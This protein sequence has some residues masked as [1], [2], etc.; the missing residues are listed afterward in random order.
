MTP[1]AVECE[2]ALK[3]PA[4]QNGL[5]FDVPVLSKSS[6]SSSSQPSA[7]SEPLEA[8]LLAWTLLLYRNSNG[9]PVQF[10]WSLSEVGASEVATFE[11]NTSTLPWAGADSVRAARD[12]IRE[13]LRQ[14][15]PADQ[16]FAVDRYTF[17]F[18]DEIAP[19][20]SASVVEDGDH[21]VSWGNIQLQAVVADGSLCIRPHWRE[22]LGASF[23]AN[24]FAQSLIEILTTTLG[25]DLAAPI[26]SVLALGD[27]DK[28]VIWG[29]NKDVPP[30]THAC[31]HTLI[32]DMVRE[33]P[34]APAICSWDG[35]FTYQEVEDHS[36][37]LAHH[38][39]S[40]GLKVGDVVPLCFEKSRWT[41]IALMAVNKAG[42][43]FV[44]MDPSQPLQRRQTMAAVV[45]AP[46]ILTSRS[47]GPSGMETAPE[48]QTV[49]VDEPTL[50]SLAKSTSPKG[51]LPDVPTDSLLYCIF[52]SGSTGVPKGVM[53]DHKTY[54]TSAIIRS[55][56]IGYA[57]DSR[58]LDF[59]SY[60]FD[61]SI[62]S[63][64]CTLLRGG[65]LCIP[66]DDDRMNDLSGA[67]RRLKVNMANMTP[68]VARI[69][70]ADI[71]PS[72]H[73]LGLGGESSSAADIANWGKET[74]IVVGYGP[75]ECTIGCTVNPSAAG[76]P[77]VSIGAG[78][79]AVIWLVDP[80]DHNKLVPVGA[81]G[82]LLVEGP[83][84]GQG[85]LGDPEKTAAA[86]IED[87]TWLLEG[88]G[89][90]PGRHGRLYKTGDLV[91]YD[92]D[93]KVGFIF[94]GRKDTQIKLRGQR[95]ELGEIEYHVKNLLPG[96]EVVAE[97]VAPQG[98][99][100]E[101][102]IV[103]FI[104]DREA[105][106]A[107]GASTE[108]RH[109]ELSPRVRELVAELDDK[110]SQVLPI[111]MVPSAYIGLNKIPMLVS[112][113]TDRKS[114]RA[115]GAKVPLSTA[116]TSTTTITKPTTDAEVFLRDAWC[117]LLSLEE[118]QVSTTHNFF[119]LGGE[120]VLAMKLVPLVREKGYLMTVADVFNRPKLADMAKQM[121]LD[122][123]V[124][125]DMDVPAF[126]LLR[127]DMNREATLAEAA[128]QCG[129]DV[130]AIEDVYPCAPMQ[131]IHVAFYT[132][133]TESYVAQRVA[134]I[135]SGVSID[136]LQAA[137]NT[138]A[139][140]SAILRTRIVEFKQHG[141]MQVVID[142]PAQ[143]QAAS[144]DLDAFLEADAAVPMT[145]STP[146]CRFTI[147]H[148]EVLDK[149][150]FVW[151]AHHAI[152]DGWST[153]LIVEHVKAVYD[154]QDVSRTAEFKH[155]IRFLADPAR[156]ESKTYWREQLEGATGPQFPALPSRSFI[157]EPDALE[158]R[159][160]AVDPA[161]RSEATVATVIRAA[162]ALVASQYT[163]SDDVVYGETFS[164]R[165][166]PI[167]GAEQIEGP[168]L[169]TVPVRIRV[170]RAA[171]VQEF[172]RAIQDQSVERAAHEHLG[173]QNIR[174]LSPDA[175]IA[176]EVMMGLVVQP[177]LPEV[178][179]QSDEDLPMFRSGDQALEA[180]HF[181]SY[182]IMMAASLEQTGFRLVASFD[183]RIVSP[184]R[185]KRVLAQ[186][187]CA[188]TQLRGDQTLPLSAMTCVSADELA[189]IWSLNRA[190]PL[191]P[192]SS[193][194]AGD[195]YP[196]VRYVPWVV[197][198]SNEGL[199]VP[200]G[201]VGELV[202]EGV[203]ESDDAPAWLVTGVEGIAGRHG[204]LHHT[205][206]L[207]KYADDMSLVFMGRKE[208]MT[209]IDGH[210]I[211]LAE[212]D[213]ALQK[214]LPADTAVVS[215]LVLPRGSTGQT[216]MV[217]AF[218]Q[219]TLQSEAQ[220]HDLDFEAVES[221]P[222]ATAI[223]TELATAVNGLNKAMLE[224]LP[225]YA[226]PS[227]C[228]PIAST[229]DNAPVDVKA[230]S[231]LGELVSLA[232]VTQLRKSLANLERT[233]AAS[234]TM[235]PKERA[236][237]PMWAKFLGLDE[238][239]I[240]LDDNFFR[241]GGDSIVAM[242]MVSALR[243][244][245]L[246]LSVADMFQ[247]MKLRDMAAAIVD[248]NPEP[249]KAAK[250]YAPFS[251]LGAPN[252]EA[253]LTETVRPALADASWTIQD[254]LP[255]TD[256]QTRDVKSSISAPRS[257]MQYNMLYLEDSID[258]ALLLDSFR[259]LV[260]Q[261]A[262]LRTVFVQHAERTLQVVLEN[263]ALPFSELTT[264]EP[265]DAFCKKLA[266]EDIAND[267]AFA[268]GASFLHLFVV[269]GKAEKA[270]MI[271]IS[272]AQYDG[273][274]LPEL[275]RQLELRYRGEDVPASAPF[276]SYLQHLQDKRADNLSFWRGVLDGS[277]PT[278]IITPA[279]PSAQTAFM[280]K[281]VDVSARSPDTTF[282]MLLS[283]AWAKVMATHL[284]VDDVTFGNIVS[285]RNVEL[286]GVDGVMGPCYQ[287]MPVRVRFEPG[288]TATRLLDVVR[289][290]YLEGSQRATVGFDELK[291][292]L[293]WSPSFYGSFVN[294]LDKEFFDAV[295]FAGT[296]C[297]VDYSIP[298]PEPATP[299]RVVSFV[300]GGATFVGI[301]ADEERRPFWEA[302]LEE[303]AA[304]VE[305]FVTSPEAVL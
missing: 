180:L 200:V 275:L 220:V 302:R 19:D 44:L 210:V 125:V 33:Q 32:S 35:D 257:S 46:L 13:Y 157:P 83:V 53:I 12:G 224:T 78:T 99:G 140:K 103:A 38:L 222:V 273:V 91:R 18:N 183:S 202:L 208:A 206:D 27:V 22:P 212:T 169:A 75:S 6:S 179:E 25:D 232:L 20:G 284:G 102:M 34:D 31:M 136:K 137:W 23:L 263:L 79:G 11:V 283:A 264:E 10:S 93:G 235:T 170:D 143:W 66:T 240:S 156:E 252:V 154:G 37:L 292:E 250:V 123:N 59:T 116:A 188:V 213:K 239:D 290:Q 148:D 218:V 190:A 237:L 259:H 113:K 216:P 185:V 303:L 9:S 80:A 219:E 270:L 120:S 54:T 115:L 155:F 147:V 130:T 254:V 295:P 226:I 234:V 233:I 100:K 175:Q 94:V 101:S 228:I 14:Q 121:Q 114:L 244:A 139:A 64:L 52:T 258:A 92:P 304:A 47:L 279:E 209:T 70:D 166:L 87:P 76:K 133:S 255:V 159:F 267:A 2:P 294:H 40:L 291:Q 246:R 299:P 194:A 161:A 152:Y 98:Q 112:G 41:V 243:R 138:V 117:R 168:I 278:E 29:W 256:T 186:F 178:V 195:V 269:Q 151:T 68:S 187:E 286:E 173:I 229:S 127:P 171:T 81:V 287:Y 211:N 205:G 221:L 128:E 42:A 288:W 217:V 51:A 62:D 282:A 230:V 21:T 262:I 177:K 88:G 153:D 141:F 109:Q 65:C 223:S 227:I 248:S 300:E 110:L 60:A 174:R 204:K 277:S 245:G 247:N 182:P 146:L 281:P 119:M 176:C 242:R 108:A 86:F 97:I 196:V 261:H 77:Y 15:L 266:E 198:P 203:G 225:P 193:L 8:L 3:K 132:R 164:G 268:L 274:S 89:G 236:L 82:E 301:E 30:T 149:R 253:F 71:V 276:T 189:E 45:Q 145:P 131:E 134:E 72:L 162:W 231:K 129:V 293:S 158:E 207:V 28:A 105:A 36:D 95:V 297:R 305:A 124:K 50:Q 56:A 122:D 85:Y 191:A 73:S 144:S 165:T 5:W 215:Q 214:F 285:G 63:M 265:V 74:R 298:H 118:D 272:H 199:L 172:L 43:A 241:L 69:L 111:Y 61:V 84:V 96:T 104:A 24:H 107:E 55:G 67:I 238:A 48:A 106:K 184:A 160:I 289:G 150:Y 181:N 197:H 57:R 260:A 280:T 39:I 49:V 142:Q 16:P 271:R 192:S 296:S 135:P 4:Q 7:S 126:S 201:T 58:A 251:L 249:E 26:D 163:M 1:G 167:P 17:S 90:V